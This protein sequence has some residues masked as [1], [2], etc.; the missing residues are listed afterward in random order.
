MISLTIRSKKLEGEAM[1]HT[2]IKIDGVSKWLDLHL[3]VD[4]KKWKEVS[5]S[6]K[7]QNNYLDKLG[8]S[9]K[10]ADKRLSK[11]P[12]WQKREKG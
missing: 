4:I 12:S 7:K 9:K 5:T 3:P 8:H 1:L 6:Q 10:I 2:R 11:T